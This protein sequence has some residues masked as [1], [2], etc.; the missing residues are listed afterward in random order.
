VERRGRGR[1]GVL[2]CDVDVM[3]I[4][5]LGVVWWLFFWIYIPLIVVLWFVKRGG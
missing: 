1:L 5:R 2:L 4:W 3:K